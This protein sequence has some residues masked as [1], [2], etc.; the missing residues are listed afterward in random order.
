M[1][2]FIL[3]LISIFI[4]GKSQ[5][6]TTE[7]LLTS[8]YVE[9]FDWFGAWWFN[10]PTTG[11]FSDISVTPTLSAVIFGSGNNTYE[12]DWYTLPSVTVDPTK[13]HVFKMRLAAQTISSP[14]AATAGLDGGDYITVQL[15][16]NGGSYVSELRVSGFSNATWDYSSNAIATKVVNGSLTT[17][18]P[19]SGG[20]RNSLGDGYS[21]IELVIPAGPTTIAIDI[22]A[23]ANRP[24]EDWWMDNFE[25]F[26]VTT[27]LPVELLSFDVTPI[28]N[29]Y[30]RLEW[31]TASEI[32]N[33]GFEVLRSVDGENFEYIAWIS[34]NGNQTTIHK[35]SYEDYSIEKGITYYYQL[36]QIDYDG[37][38]EYFDIKPVRLSGPSKYSEILSIKYYSYLGEEFATKPNLKNYIKCISYPEGTVCEKIYLK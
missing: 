34:G 10:N 32:N 27:L 2:K 15:S 7:T 26:E 8:D 19:S 30:A 18:S 36:K 4:L 1:K 3:L 9:S 29:Q 22:Q 6:Q 12:Q 11:Y 13:D 35:Y 17:F 24:G 23:R 37:Q 20:N 25:L 28:N 16:Q 21:Y 14:L 38:Y 33:N 5:T 31:A